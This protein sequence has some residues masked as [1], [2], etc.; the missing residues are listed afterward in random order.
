MNTAHL[1]AWMT[2]LA[3][4]FFACILGVRN[5]G[6]VL[7]LEGQVETM[8]RKLEAGSEGSG[9]V[10][11]ELERIR[12]SLDKIAEEVRGLRDADAPDVSPELRLRL[13][14]LEQLLRETQDRL[15]VLP[16]A[17]GT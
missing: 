11:A 15:S 1:V 6:A 8:G 10:Q 9:G 4:A 13:E 17:D 3:L 14:E 2:C 16:E 12:R 7:R 5:A